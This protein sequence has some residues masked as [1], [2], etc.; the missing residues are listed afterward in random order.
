VLFGT[1]YGVTDLSWNPDYYAI[2]TVQR[3]G[4]AVQILSPNQI[5]II[6]NA[7]KGPAI[8]FALSG[9]SF[10]GVDCFLESTRM[11]K[12]S[13]NAVGGGMAAGFVMASMHRRLDYMI[14]TSM[15]CGLCMGVVDFCGNNVFSD[16]ERMDYIRDDSRRESFVESKEMKD[17]KE[18]YKKYFV[19]ENGREIS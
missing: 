2:T 5:S 12:D 3:G 11:K 15:F 4:K 8:W 16:W 9:I 14:A 18:K 13:W 10:S 1:V 7:C 6:V 17:L 19:D